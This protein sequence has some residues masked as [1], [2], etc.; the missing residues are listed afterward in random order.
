ME[1][2]SKLTNFLN[3]A[4]KLSQCNI[5]LTDKSK[6]IFTSLC[7]ENDI[8]IRKN[9]SNDLINLTKL[10]IDDSNFA[11]TTIS[12]ENCCIPLLGNESINYTAQMILPIFHKELDGFLVFFSTDR[13]YLESNLRFART[14][15]HF[16]EKLSDDC[17]M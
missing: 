4:H 11:Y 12:G 2:N 7:F 10:F 1:I 8:F 13:K 5:L 9:I 15:Q 17:N 3:D 6:F 16:T 14:T